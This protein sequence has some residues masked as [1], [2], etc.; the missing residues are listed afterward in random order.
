MNNKIPMT[1]KIAG[2]IV[3]ICFDVSEFSK[4]YDQ[5]HPKNPSKLFEISEEI[6]KGFKWFT[7]IDSENEMYLKTN[8]YIHSVNKA[9]ELYQDSNVVMKNKDKIILQLTQLQLHLS[10]LK[11]EFSTK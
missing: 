9:L 11:K 8:E 7:N 10:N 3:K 1:E 2:E 5:E 4:L 6:K